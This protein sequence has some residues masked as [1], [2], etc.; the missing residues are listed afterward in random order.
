MRISQQRLKKESYITT[1]TE[2]IKIHKKD[3]DKEKDHS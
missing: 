2:F 1:V 3:W